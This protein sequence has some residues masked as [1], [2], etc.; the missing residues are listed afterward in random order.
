MSYKFENTDDF[1]FQ[2]EEETERFEPAAT[3]NYIDISSNYD[4][5]GVD[6]MG[7]YAG[8]KYKKQHNWVRISINVITSI[9]L[10][11]SI[12]LTVAMGWFI[13]KANKTFTTN[14]EGIET[15]D[16]DDLVKSESS[17]STNFLV[18][19]C[20]WTGG[21]LTDV[22]VVVCMDHKKKT[23]S[24]LQ[25]PRDTYVGYLNS[26][27]I[28]SVYSNAREGE[29]KI[30]ALRRCLSSQLGIPIDHYIL[31]SIES[32]VDVVDA[33]GGVEMNLPNAIYIED[34]LD[35]GNYYYIGPGKVTL[36]GRDAIGFMRKRA[37]NQSED[38]NYDGSDIGRVKQQRKFYAALFKELQNMS[39]GEIWDIGQI[40]FEKEADDKTRIQTDL[41]L[42]EAAAYALD[43]MKIDD[44]DI[45]IF[46]MPGQSCYYNGG[47]Y[48][49][50][51]KD[52]YIEIYNENFNPY[53]KE[54]TAED[55]PCPEL[56]S[57]AGQGMVDSWLSTEDSTLDD[58]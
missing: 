23:V 40:C 25:I 32:A 29:L 20:D 9:V 57:I 58:Y 47:S 27:K 5:T 56:Y 53:G 12:V 44:K 6:I 1:N 48:Y 17:D 30:N 19:G 37:G 10:A 36:K 4:E 15:G 26:Y 51:H 41:T 42:N 39:T 38:V 3:D 14:E 2:S 54:L 18:V 50:I 28:N 45:H 8:K 31:F 35:F 7:A 13:N 11:V 33:I 43:V 46:G 21:K 34:P 16:Y 22:I 55:V 49:S 24:M 52:E